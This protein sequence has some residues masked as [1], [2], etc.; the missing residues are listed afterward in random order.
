MAIGSSRERA[1]GTRRRRR[2][3]R[4]LPARRRLGRDAV[5]ARIPPHGLQAGVPHPAGDAGR[6]AQ[7]ARRHPRPFLPRPGRHVR[8]RGRGAAVPPRRRAAGDLGARVAGHRVRR[9]AAGHRARVLPRRHLLA[10]GRDPA[11]RAR[12]RHPVAVDRELEA[13]PP[14]GHGHPAA[15]TASGCTSP[16]STWCATRRAPSGCSRTTCGC[17]RA[18]ATSSPTVARWPTSSP[19]RSRR[20]GS[21]RCTTTR[22]CCSPRCGP[23]RPTAP[24]TRRSSCSPPVSSTPP[25]SSTPCWPG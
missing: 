2:P 25:T 4:R 11:R 20:C 18:S 3:L 21:A 1:D 10:R 16:A 7:G 6:N 23:P 5:R 22:G 24:A 17:P 8:L 15:A 14:G 19:R 9:R 12:G 13:L